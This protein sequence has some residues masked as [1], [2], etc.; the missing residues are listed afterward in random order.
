MVQA[1]RVLWGEGMFLRPQHFQQQI[2]FS[3]QAQAGQMAP[4]TWGVR[5]ADVDNQALKSGLLRLDVLS[6]V[7]QDGFSFDAPRSEPLPLARNL[8]ELPQL[9]S[10]TLVYA[11]LPLLN[12]FGGNTL[13]AGQDAPRPTRFVSERA[14]AA[15]LYTRA[16]EAEV[17]VLR[18]H[19]RLMLEEENR[20]GYYSVPVARISKDA[21][22][23]WSQDEDFIPPLRALAGSKTLN[24]LIR[25]LLD[26]LLVKSQSL[27]AMHRE[28]SGKVMEF[29]TSDIASFWLLHTVNRNF[30]LLGHFLRQPDASPETLYL[31]LAQMAGE[32]ITFSSSHGLADI[33]AY[34][35]EDPTPVFV[36]LDE[37][38]RELLGTVISTRYAVIPLSSA[39]ASFHIGLLESDRLIEDVDYYLSVQSDLPLAQVIETV[40]F[41]LK[42]GAPDDVEKILNSALPGVRLVY[43]AQTP[44]AIPV[45]VGNH[46]FSFDPHGQIFERMQKSRS[47]CIYVPQALAELKL[48]L[49][50]VFR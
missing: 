26:I 4:N 11:C 27:S 16:I 40:P 25:R 30:P 47:I 2:L 44:S 34:R 20:D 29:G 28:R 17:T 9:G 41:K 7:F 22:G 5:R 24:Q 33:P 19:V 32:L 21:T 10:K 14:M 3:E 6:L 31:T 39:K 42:V 8:N 35:H 50:A 15:D 45:R 37:L 13:E 23:N 1:Q 38:V 12:A 18:A 36:R 43:A 46:Y 49:I 48:E